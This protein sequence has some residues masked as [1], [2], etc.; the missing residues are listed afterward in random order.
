MEQEISTKIEEKSNNSEQNMNNISG[1]LERSCVLEDH[2]EEKE[3]HEMRDRQS[4]KSLYSD[5]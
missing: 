4:K 1:Y 2:E 3:N 5:S